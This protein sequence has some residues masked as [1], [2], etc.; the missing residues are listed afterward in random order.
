[1]PI[2]FYLLDQTANSFPI[3]SSKWKRR[4]PGKAKMGLT[5]TLHKHQTLQA[6]LKRLADKIRH[7]L[8]L[9]AAHTPQR[10]RHSIGRK[11]VDPKILKSAKSCEENSF[12]LSRSAEENST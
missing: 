5:I 8:P 6:C 12:V 4:P 2:M 7:A 10:T 3:R 11:D 9:P 1:M